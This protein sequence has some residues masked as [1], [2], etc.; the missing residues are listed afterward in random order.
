MVRSYVILPSFTSALSQSPFFRD[1]P[2]RPARPLFFLRPP[3]QRHCSL[4]RIDCHAQAFFFSPWFGFWYHPL[5]PFFSLSFATNTGEMQI[6]PPRDDK[7][8]F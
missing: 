5:N 8:L 4:E 3:P 7:V 2:S 1:P 6:V